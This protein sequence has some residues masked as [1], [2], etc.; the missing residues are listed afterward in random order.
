[1]TVNQLTVQIQELQ[2]EVNSLN[3]SRHFHD[4]T[5]SSSGFSHVPSHPFMVPS[6]FGM[7]CLDSCQPD[8]RNVF[9][10]PGNVFDYPLA[11]NEP[12]ASCSRNV[13]LRTCVS[14]HKKICREN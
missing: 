14:K 9:G 6:S 1:M 7:P 3:D 13:S 2:D 10:T 12:T 4:P 11:P 8:F 5:A